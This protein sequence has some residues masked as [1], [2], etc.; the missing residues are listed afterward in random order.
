MGSYVIGTIWGKGN[1]CLHGVQKGGR[2]DLRFPGNFK[3]WAMLRWESLWGTCPIIFLPFVQTLLELWSV[4][5]R[6]RSL[7]LPRL[8]FLL[9][10]LPSRPSQS[11]REGFILISY[12]HLGPILGPK[13]THPDPELSSSSGSSSVKMGTEGHSGTGA[14]TGP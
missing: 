14:E 3:D 8:L 2:G 9:H 5:P 7:S 10:A 1:E 11:G 6:P 12:S 13:R 4:P